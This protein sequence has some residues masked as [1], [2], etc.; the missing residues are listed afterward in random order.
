M[1]V[2]FIMV[3]HAPSNSVHHHVWCDI[4]FTGYFSLKLEGDF[5][6]LR[7]G[8]VAHLQYLGQCHLRLSYTGTYAHLFGTIV[9]STCYRMYRLTV[10][11]FCIVII[12]KASKYLC[13]IILRWCL[14][15]V[16]SHHHAVNPVNCF[17]HTNTQTKVWWHHVFS[18]PAVAMLLCN[19]GVMDQLQ[20]LLASSSSPTSPSGCPP[21]ALLCYSH[22]LLSSLLTLQHFHSTKVPTNIKLCI[23]YPEQRQ[24]Q[25]VYDLKN[26]LVL[27]LSGSDV[28]IQNCPHTPFGRVSTEYF[29]LAIWCLVLVLFFF[30][31][32]LVLTPAFFLP[33]KVQKCINW[34]LETALQRL[35]VQ[36]RNTDNVLLGNI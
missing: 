19:N 2:A 34:N 33:F 18:T 11:W 23:F 4:R 12:A 14:Q 26:R 31:C 3:L 29:L 32:L 25:K 15:C 35:L 30:G 7:I 8:I 28:V 10:I 20:T 27:D 1:P 9:D 17:S 6:W 16:R 22:L 36:K 24:K 21:S 5:N 13:V